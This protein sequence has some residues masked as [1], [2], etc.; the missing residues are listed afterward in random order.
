MAKGNRS[1]RRGTLADHK[2]DCRCPG[3]EARRNPGRS[4][5]LV[6]VP[7]DLVA[8]ADARGGVV[9]VLRNARAGVE[10][11]TDYEIETGYRED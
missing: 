6:R 2:P 3:C 10:P 7:L 5:K 4:T 9:S 1:D 8:W 11:L